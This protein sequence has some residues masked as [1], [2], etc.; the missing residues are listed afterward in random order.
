MTDTLT[1]HQMRERFPVTARALRF[2]EQKGLLA[3]IREGTKRLYTLR[4]RA[5]L[6]L[7]LRGKRFGIPLDE[8]RHLL[9]LYE[10]EGAQAQA[11][12]W[13]ETLR[14]RQKEIREERARMDRIHDEIYRDRNEWLAVEQVNAH[15][16]AAE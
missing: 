9:D 12:A 5:R 2:Y 10:T 15:P 7:I 11:K 8:I 16:E 13:G 3:P 6:K 14:R 4:D 1:I